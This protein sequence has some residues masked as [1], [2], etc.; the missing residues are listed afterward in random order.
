MMFLFNN[1]EKRKATKGKSVSSDKKKRRTHKGP[2]LA[3]PFDHSVNLA[4][5]LEYR[6]NSAE[7]KLF[8]GMIIGEVVNMAYEL[9][10]RANLCLAYATGS[11]NSIIAEEMELARL[12]LEKAQKSN[13]EL[14]LHIEEL[15]KVAEEEWQKYSATLA[16]VR[17][18]GRQLQQANE[19]M[20]K[21]N[22]GLKLDL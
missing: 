15:Q 4:D 13:E 22:E 17:S 5:R 20:K 7:K 16:K 14:N 11:T 12:D 19:E 9:N 1:G 21:A 18:V 6:L 3:G 2:L 10:V 8:Q